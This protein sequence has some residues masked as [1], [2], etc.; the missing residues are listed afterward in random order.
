MKLRSGK[1]LNE[2]NNV[3]PLIN[4]SLI[5]KYNFIRNIILNLITSNDN[6]KNYPYNEKE[7][8]NNRVRVCSELYYIIDYYYHELKLMRKYA[9]TFI[10][11]TKSKAKYIIKDIDFV[12]NSPRFRLRNQDKTSA[13]N[14]KSELIKYIKKK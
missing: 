14:F 2:Q 9:P 5:N 13:E 11:V 3:I 8:F 10:N 12:L 6:L 1:V 4:K 7:L